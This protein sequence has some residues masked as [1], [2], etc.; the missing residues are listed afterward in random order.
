MSV[1][2]LTGPPWPAKEPQ[3][4]LSEVEFDLLGTARLPNGK[5][6][7]DDEIEA[8]RQSQA[9]ADYWHRRW[10]EPVMRFECGEPVG[11]CCDWPT[12][13]WLLRSLHSMHP[14][15]ESLADDLEWMESC[16]QVSQFC[17]GGEFP[18]DLLAWWIDEMG[19]PR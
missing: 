7:P 13:Y 6:V 19:H 11:V 17:A 3:R 9:A 1:E 15:D 12:V 8:M 4:D 2:H 16:A 14:R 10:N 18:H 5:A